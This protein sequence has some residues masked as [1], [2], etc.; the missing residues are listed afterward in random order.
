[1][2][3]L[4]CCYVI[5]WQ[6]SYLCEQATEKVPNKMAGEFILTSSVGALVMW[7]LDLCFMGLHWGQVWR[8]RYSKTKLLCDDTVT[9]ILPLS[10]D[11]TSLLPEICHLWCFNTHTFPRH[12]IEHV[13]FFNSRAH[14]PY[15]SHSVSLVLLC[16]CLCKSASPIYAYT[17]EIKTQGRSF[18]YKTKC[19]I[20]LDCFGT[21]C[22]HSNRKLILY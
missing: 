15:R 1:M 17:M 22:L 16:D 10:H 12:P 7:C 21:R 9:V 5:D 4:S 3:A 6:I 19:A 14:A 11:F 8:L 13:H 18:C 20:I 2:I